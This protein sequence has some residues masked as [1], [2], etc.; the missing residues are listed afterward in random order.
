MNPMIMDSPRRGNFCGVLSG[1]LL[2]VSLASSSKP[3]LQ[4][5]Q[6]GQMTLEELQKM[7]KIDVHAHI[8]AMSASGERQFVALLQKHN[9][10]WLD[11]CVVGTE[12]VKLQKKMALADRFHKNYPAKVSW[13]TSFD[14]E[15][16]GS[17]DWST[18]AIQT[19]EQGF[20]GGAV[21]VKVWKDIGMVIED[22][23]GRYV[24]ID[25]PRFA[26]VLDDIQKRGKT[27]VAHIGEPRNCWL[28]LEAMTVEGDRNYY[29]EHPKYHA[30]LH[31]EIPTYWDQIKARDRMLEKHPGLRV[32]GCH[33]GSLEFDVDELAKRLDK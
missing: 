21:A 13:A 14:L 6:A 33:L 18:T 5:T 8:N 4:S 10:K 29:K 26:P 1:L 20:A 19:I 9:L 3:S 27:L 25:D 24:M 22:P 2:A 11:I 15:N 17:P 30:F 23:D 12:C 32:V 31:P 28:P 7:P 16:W